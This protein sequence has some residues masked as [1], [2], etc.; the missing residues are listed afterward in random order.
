MRMPAEWE[1]HERTLM[2]WPTATRQRALWHD[3]LGLA[4]TAHATAAAAIARFEPVTMVANASDVDH[5]ARACGDDVE[6]VAAEIDDSWL[7]DSGPVLVRGDDGRRVGVDFGFNGWGDAFTPYDKDQRIAGALL[8][9]L[10]IG[11]IDATAV[12]L[13]GGSVAVDGTG[14]LVTTERCLLNPNRN[15][16]LD[17]AAIEDLLT[18]YLGA[19]IVVWLADG[20]AEDDGTDGHVDNVVAFTAAAK[21]LLQGCDEQA[22]PNHAIAVESRRRLE[23]AGIEVVE[24]SSLPY[25]TVAGSSNPVPYVNFYVCNGAVMVPTVD[26]GESRWLD[27]IGE[28]FGDRD[29][30]ALPGEVLAYGGGGVHCITQQ[31]IAE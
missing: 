28:E 3:Q 24:V 27:L 10:K 7:R 16:S 6:V 14:R 2:A 9:H 17:R 18:Q 5:A 21:V 13:E 8:D 29:V 26:G 31:V 30:I 19:D 4:R 15:P 11:R 25:A 20:I 1:P 22:N 12:V 23:H